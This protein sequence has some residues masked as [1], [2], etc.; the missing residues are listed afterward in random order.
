MI[1]VA[2]SLVAYRVDGLA[3]DAC[4][5]CVGD[6][7]AHLIQVPNVVGVDVTPSESRISILTDGPV[8]EHALR[9]ALEEAGCR[10]TGK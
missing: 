9:T 5:H 10:V 3:T 7:K 2:Y 1:T 8:D 4:D 6:I